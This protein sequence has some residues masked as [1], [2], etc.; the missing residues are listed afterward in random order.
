MI[1]NYLEKGG[2]W[3]S[4]KRSIGVLMGYILFIGPA[5]YPDNYGELRPYFYYIFLPYRDVKLFV[6]WKE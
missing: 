1:M 2:I 6:K 3:R 4:T 5:Y